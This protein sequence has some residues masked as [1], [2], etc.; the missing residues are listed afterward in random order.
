M[1]T[2][3]RK[4]KQNSFSLQFYKY[5]KFPGG[6]LSC[7]NDL[8]IF[9]FQGSGAYLKIVGQSF[10]CLRAS[11]ASIL[12]A[13]QNGREGWRPCRPRLYHLCSPRSIRQID[14]WI[15]HD[16]KLWRTQ[17]NDV[18]LVNPV[19]YLTAFHPWFSLLKYKVF[20]EEGGDLKALLPSDTY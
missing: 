20:G 4:E 19:Y 8:P 7:R 1:E 2:L 14:N 13:K 10:I 5:D 6:I 17:E 16:L 9:I 18:I 15:H 11:E 3:V 12:R